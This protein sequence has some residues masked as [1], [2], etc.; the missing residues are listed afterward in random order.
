MTRIAYES[1]IKYQVLVEDKFAWMKKTTYKGDGKFYSFEKHVKY[2]FEA[3]HTLQKFK[4]YYPKRFVQ[5]FP[6][7]ISDPRLKATKE[8]FCDP[9]HPANRDFTL[10]FNKL[11]HSLGITKLTHARDAR[12]KQ[13]R[14]VFFTC[15]NHQNDS[16]PNNSNGNNQQGGGKGGGGKRRCGNHGGP[17]EGT[18]TGTI[19]KKFY[20]PKIY[21]T[22]IKA[23]RIEHHSLMIPSNNG[24]PHPT[25]YTSNS[26]L[27]REQ[28]WPKCSHAGDPTN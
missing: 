3:K 14:R 17:K 1:S 10:C 28:L 4:A 6:N 11:S 9:K 20:A 5:M 27:H 16:N 2:W 22:F 24:S 12:D 25:S 8:L 26:N 15:T 13:P 19:E 23:Q 21:K 18:Y 7:S